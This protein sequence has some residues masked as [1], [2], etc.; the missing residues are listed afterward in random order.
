VAGPDRQPANKDSAQSNA[1]ALS[2]DCRSAA[3][4]QPLDAAT[5]G[6]ASGRATRS[7]REP[8]Q[9]VDG[10][11]VRSGRPV[12]SRAARWAGALQAGSNGRPT[13]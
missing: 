11:R 7:Q 5:R 10:V 8:A 2:L 4:T 6:R 9:R 1:S 3:T 13:H 12:G